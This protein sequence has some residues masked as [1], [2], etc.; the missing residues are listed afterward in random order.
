GNCGLT[1]TQVRGVTGN[2]LV[3]ASPT[4]QPFVPQGSSEWKSILINN[5]SAAVRTDGFRVKFVFEGDGGNNFY[6]DD[7]NI[8]NATITDIEEP[9]RSEWISVF[10]NPFGN[11]L[12]IDMNVWAGKSVKLS[13]MDIA[14]KEV[15]FENITAQPEW[16]MLKFDEHIFSTGMYFLHLQSDETKLVKKI[17]KH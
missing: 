3:T 8:A 16:Y 15:Y 2:T 13:L 17:I 10:P 1:W 5:L 4:N 7:I 9:F 14:G 12:F 11:E 6:L